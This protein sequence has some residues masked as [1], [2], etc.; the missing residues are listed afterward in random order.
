MS[1]S[2]AI[3][4]TESG[5]RTLYRDAALTDARSPELRLG[6]SVLVEDDRI[7]WIRPS[8]EEGA[9]AA[10]A[11]SGDGDRATLEVVD[12]S[13]TTI[14]PSMVDTHQRCPVC[15]QPSCPSTPCRKMGTGG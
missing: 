4:M 5:S 10:W 15:L 9:L 11:R 13:G 8:D 7:T 6:V 14:V 12:A 2:G 3:P 1:R